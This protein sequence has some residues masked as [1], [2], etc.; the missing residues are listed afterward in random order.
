[1]QMPLPERFRVEKKREGR[2]R[3]KGKKFKSLG[4]AFAPVLSRGERTIKV[5]SGQKKEGRRWLEIK[6]KN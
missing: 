4:K 1:M 3:K 6:N 5:V 2:Y